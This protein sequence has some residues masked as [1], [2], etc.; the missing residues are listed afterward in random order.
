MYL[1]FS[2]ASNVYHISPGRVCHGSEIAYVFDSAHLA[3]FSFSPEEEILSGDVITYWTNFAWSGNPNF[4]T[5]PKPVT[6]LLSASA[7]QRKL[8]LKDGIKWPAYGKA[9]N[10]TALRF[11]TPESELVKNYKDEDCSFWDAISYSQYR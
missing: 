7:P 6:A 1:T 11:K 2:H 4:S 10:W 9:S 3:N 8:G 5:P